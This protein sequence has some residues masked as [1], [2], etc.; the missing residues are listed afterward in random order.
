MSTSRVLLDPK[1][2][3]EIIF[4]PFDFSGKLLLGETIS[5]VTS[6]TPTVWSGVDANP[7]A[8]YG[9]AF[10]IDSNS[11]RALPKI[12]A[13]VLGVIY[14]IEVAVSTSSTRTLVLDGL[15]AI[16]PGPM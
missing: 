4:P 13:G 11:T 7:S 3:A 6:V 2:V 15:L 9:G 5:T 16:I 10:N 8:I 14:N 12:I 1:R